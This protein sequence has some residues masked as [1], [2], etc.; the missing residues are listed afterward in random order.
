MDHEVMPLLSHLEQV[1]PEINQ[2]LD[3]AAQLSH[4]AS[5]LPKVFR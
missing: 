1:V 2:L 3:R 5:R 4:M